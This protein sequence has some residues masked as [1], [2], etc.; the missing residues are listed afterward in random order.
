LIKVC[1][2]LKFRLYTPR[3]GLLGARVVIV[4]VVGPAIFVTTLV[5]LCVL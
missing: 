3:D 5:L 2:H 4:M 1:T